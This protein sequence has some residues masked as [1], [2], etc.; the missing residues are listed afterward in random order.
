[1]SLLDDFWHFCCPRSFSFLVSQRTKNRRGT[2]SNV[3]L[4]LCCEVWFYARLRYVLDAFFFFV[5]LTFDNTFVMTQLV[6]SPWPV[7]LTILADITGEWQDSK[8]LP[9][10][11]LVILS[12]QGVKTT[13]RNEYMFC[14]FEKES[15]THTHCGGYFF[16][17][18]HHVQEY[19]KITH[20]DTQCSKLW[21]VST[22][23]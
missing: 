11:T 10:C 13:S 22:F 18:S 1:M 23:S 14:T 12:S 5:V 6:Q 3:V 19:S 7:N 15:L 9:Y 2:S 4:S 20:R 8:A 21:N 17:S 16:S